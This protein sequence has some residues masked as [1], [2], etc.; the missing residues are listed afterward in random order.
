MCEITYHMCMHIIFLIAC[1]CVLWIHIKHATYHA[2]ICTTLYMHHTEMYVSAFSVACSQ[3]YDKDLHTNY[4]DSCS[5]YWICNFHP[6]SLWQLSCP[7]SCYSRS[8]CPAAALFTISAVEI[9]AFT[10]VSALWFNSSSCH[11]SCSLLHSLL[12]QNRRRHT[13]HTSRDP[14]LA[15]MLTLQVLQ[16]RQ[17][18]IQS[19]SPAV[20]AV[21]GL[22]PRQSSV[23]LTQSTG[24]DHPALESLVLLFLTDYSRAA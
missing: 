16:S 20:G 19:L 10:T 11:H 5:C 9:E 15:G 22:E 7:L 14:E 17:A 21:L 6:S 8:N 2:H 13:T 24:P 1:Q 23:H 3:S 4:L 12:M 18:K